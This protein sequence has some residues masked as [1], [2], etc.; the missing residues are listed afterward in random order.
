MEPVTSGDQVVWPKLKVRL[1]APERFWDLEMSEVAEKQQ[2]KAHFERGV[3]RND[4]RGM[5][6]QCIV[7]EENTRFVIFGL[8]ADGHH[9]RAKSDG[10]IE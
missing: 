5:I 10:N 6:R 1:G 4:G 8:A 7:P 9:Y 3:V 2:G